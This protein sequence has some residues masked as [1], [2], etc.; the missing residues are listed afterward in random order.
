MRAAPRRDAA[1]P[2]C[3]E[4]AGMRDPIEIVPPDL[5]PYRDGNTGIPHVL[6]F[7]SGVPGPHV[8]LCAL[9]HGNELSGAV[10]LDRLLRAGVRPLRGRLSF[11]FANVAAFDRFDPAAP[12]A[13]RFLDEDLNRVW[14][15]AV[16]DGPRR[17]VEL[18]R[19]RALRPLI[20]SADVLLDLHSMQN[21]TAPLLLS[22]TRR[23]TRAFARALGYPP[24]IV[25]DAG[26]P[27]GRRLRDYPRFDDPD[28]PALAL[29]AEC[30]AHWRAE[31][32]AV[33]LGCCLRLLDHLGMLGATDLRPPPADP[34][35]RTI[36]VTEAVIIETDR[37]AFAEDFQG[38]ERLPAGALI[39]RDGGRAIR[40]P[41]DDCVL[42]M[43]SRR[44]PR[45]GQTAVR[46]GRD[47]PAT[48]ADTA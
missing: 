29:L 8:L 31:S 23:K 33:A 36:A 46:L 44:P 12:F 5:A 43:P 24:L 37:F 9:V 39:A 40:A 18:D 28:G 21:P 1:P 3:P 13:S 34:A 6:G 20:D 22:G 27:S 26:H 42:I 48:E 15:P 38:M 4:P 19:A 32:C 25:A 10:A 14:D 41:Y 47:L 2:R 30:G 7:D 16:L 11:A 45:R 17:S 35:P